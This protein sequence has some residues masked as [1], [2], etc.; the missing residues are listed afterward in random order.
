MENLNFEGMLA[1]PLTPQATSNVVMGHDSTARERA[2]VR[3]RVEMFY[4]AKE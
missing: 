1:L 2:T 3:V 4:V